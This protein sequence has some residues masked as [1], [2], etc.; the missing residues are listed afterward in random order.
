MLEA[1]RIRPYEREN[2]PATAA[3]ACT[4]AAIRCGARVA[5]A[6]PPTGAVIFGVA[7]VVGTADFG[8]P[9]GAR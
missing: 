7:A 6:A 3:A 9:G 1:P 8:P 4:A 2:V 5:V